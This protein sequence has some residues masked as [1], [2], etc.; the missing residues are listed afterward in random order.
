MGDV[1]PNK[2]RHAAEPGVTGIKPSVP[3]QLPGIAATT[4]PQAGLAPPPHTAPGAPPPRLAP[5]PSAP[6]GHT[7]PAS[8]GRP[9]SVASMWDAP[10]S[11]PPTAPS[12]PSMPPPAT[13]APSRAV[14]A[15]PQRAFAEAGDNAFQPMP[16]ET[17]P[18]APAPLSPA[19]QLTLPKLPDSLLP[20]GLIRASGQMSTPAGPTPHRLDAFQTTDVTRSVDATRV[21]TPSAHTGSPQDVAGAPPVMRPPASPP[22]RAPQPLAGVSPTGRRGEAP[23]AG[24]D[25]AYG[26][27]VR[28][29]APQ[30]PAAPAQ[31][32]A[33][34]QY[35]PPTQHGAPAQPGAPTQHGA[36]AQPGAP[37][38]Q[39]AP[40]Q[41]VPPPA[42]PNLQAMPDATPSDRFAANQEPTR[43]VLSAPTHPP[44]ARQ[45]AAASASK[46]AASGPQ[47]AAAPD[48]PDLAQ[49]KQLSGGL[50]PG[51]PSQP[52]WRRWWV[53]A[54]AIG[55][56]VIALVVTIIAL[57]KR[58]SVPPVGT[59]AVTTSPT[60][61]ATAEVSTAVAPADWPLTGLPIG[62]NT[63]GPALCIK[64]ENSVSA[65]PQLGI[66][67]A[68]IVYEEVVEGG[69]TRFMAVFQSTMPAQVEPVRSIRPMDPPMATPLGCALVFSGGQAPFVSAAKRT[70]L[71]LIYQDH[72]DAGF[73][74]DRKRSAPHNVI[75]DTK[76]FLAAAAKA[77]LVAPPP[78]FLYPGVGL[79]S[80]AV[81]AGKLTSRID[82]KMSNGEQPSWKWDTKTSKWLR[83]E[84]SKKATVVGGAQ[85]AAV[86]VVMLSV[87]VKNT[88][89]KDPAGNPVP[90]TQLVGQGTG[91]LASGG[92]TMPIKWS[93]AS[94]DKQIVLTDNAGNPV[95]LT[96]GNTWVELVPTTGSIKTTA[97]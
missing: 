24:F 3:E 91:L 36:P 16:W 67:S 80:S 20:P 55:V 79:T 22:A 69:I 73:S 96:P 70:G 7:V 46:G 56:I 53:L 2:P 44:T 85:I 88:S 12:A 75:G 19:F 23:P 61:S 26:S 17:A 76:T 65:R 13:S 60:V 84:G 57:N 62:K 71:T 50:P 9:A 37:T 11:A 43:Q 77:K 21:V 83:S 42:V 89:Y 39:G 51:G 63:S 38:R 52:L 31:P 87:Q 4:E 58:T 64:I 1:M 29:G 48:G 49:T 14:G 27:Y 10:R 5:P 6:G 78:A 34:A 74:R 72:G 25:P 68:D 41:F 33:P 47:S 35:G 45:G 54:I 66:D 28:R 92:W 86:N 95:T 93:K 32:G 90:E 18:A 94:S 8:P 30:E 97:G 82:L 59:P 81:Q 40:T 15:P